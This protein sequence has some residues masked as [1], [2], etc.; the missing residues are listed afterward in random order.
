MFA[1][2]HANNRMVM[3]VND[4]SGSIQ[5][6]NLPYTIG[7]DLSSL[8]S[9]VAALEATASNHESRLSQEEQVSNA[10]VTAAANS[11]NGDEFLT[12]LKDLL[13]L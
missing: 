12:T 6:M 7:E 1:S 8:S 3:V 13:G 4:E 9:S 5:E 11:N 2:D 10:L